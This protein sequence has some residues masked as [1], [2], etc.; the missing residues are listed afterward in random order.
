METQAGEGLDWSSFDLRS[1]LKYLRSRDEAVVRRTLRRLH[2]Q[3]WHAKADKMKTLLSAAGALKTAIDM[4]DA[5]I[6][7]CRI[8]RMWVR[9]S[10]RNLMS[11]RMATKFNESVQCDILFYETHILLHLL[12]ECIRWTVCVES[13]SRETMDILRSLVVN[14]FQPFGAPEYIVAD[15]EGA[16]ASDTAATLLDRWGCQ[17]ILRA[18]G[19]H[20]EMVER[21]HEILRQQL[22]VIGSQLAELGIVVEFVIQLAEA[23]LAK[24]ALLSV[25]NESPYKALYGRVPNM[26]PQLTDRPG[27]SALDDAE[28]EMTGIDRHVHTVR[29][30]AVQSMVQAT[31]QQR[32]TLALK[33]KARLSIEE[34]ELKT[35]DL[36]EFWRTPSHKDTPGWKGPARVTDL[37]QTEHGTVGTSWPTADHPALQGCE[38]QS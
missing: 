10:P 6:D 7:T 34:L 31:A 4:I 33:S 3:W 26:L 32:A 38:R 2:L 15:G 17:R 19:Q 37:S 12:D 23:V 11:I 27:L 24:N 18:P 16:L 14:W 35:G 21:H 20:A 13:P 25:G 36:V 28:G 22:H 9:P 30:V 5:V 8:C 1:A 29:E